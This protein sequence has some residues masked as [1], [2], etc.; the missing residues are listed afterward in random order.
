MLDSVLIAREVAESAVKCQM[1]GFILKLDFRKAYDRV[2]WNFL[3]IVLGQKGFDNRWRKWMK[4]CV[5][6]E[7]YAILVNGCQLETLMAS[8]A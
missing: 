7:N 3:D 2:D 4:G 6:T 5:S 8:K 1:K